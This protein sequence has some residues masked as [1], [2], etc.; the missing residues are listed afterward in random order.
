MSKSGS[1]TALCT[2][3]EDYIS[4]QLIWISIRLLPK[5]KSKPR[6]MDDIISFMLMNAGTQRTTNSTRVDTGVDLVKQ[7]TQVTRL[8]TEQVG[9]QRK[10]RP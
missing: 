2:F 6:N 10:K 1:A 4:P 5:W 9:E 8:G 3:Q 7:R